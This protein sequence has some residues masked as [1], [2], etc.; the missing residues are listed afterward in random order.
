NNI[1]GIYQYILPRQQV[2]IIPYD[3]GYYA[4]YQVNGFSEFW[5][6][7][8]GTGQDQPLGVLL[9]TFTA[10]KV[11]TTGLLQWS[12]SKEFTIDSFIIEKSF[13][14]I[15]FS[16]IG[17]V[18][19]IA[20]RSS[21]RLYQF[22]DSFPLTGTNYYRL[23]ILNADG[24]YQYSGVVTLNFSKTN[25]VIGVYPN[26]VIKGILYVNTSSSCNK[27]ELYD[28]LG[29]LVKAE[30]KNGLQ[31]NIST[32]KLAKGLYVVRIS[33]DTGDSIKKIIVE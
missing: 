31:N 2:K 17:T 25:F 5:I 32:T 6:N 13:D 15:S 19:A 26:P 22:I 8:G 24:N 33:T 30:N 9:K 28:V 20:D 11:D 21:I 12:L 1:H 14:G 7:G 10:T 18:K 23:R 4:E 27:I 3:N 16:P 29:R